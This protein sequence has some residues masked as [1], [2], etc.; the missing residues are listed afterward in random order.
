MNNPQPW[1][2]TMPAAEVAA[3]ILPLLSSSTHA[4]EMDAIA[5]DR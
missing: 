4:H 2:L 5:P 1:W 3:T